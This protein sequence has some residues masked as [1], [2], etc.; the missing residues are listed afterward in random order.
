MGRA[1]GRDYLG[2]RVTGP[3]GVGA[4]VVWVGS[5]TR[6]LFRETGGAISEGFLGSKWHLALMT[7]DFSATYDRLHGDDLIYND[8]LFRDMCYCLE[9]ALGNSQFWF[10]YIVASEERSLGDSAEG[11]LRVAVSICHQLQHE[12]RNLS[13]LCW[14]QTLSNQAKL[15]GEPML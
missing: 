8:Q 7:A 13:H 14:D 4:S 3:R 6:L 1:I 15:D 11:G 12:V 5:G 9:D 10:L 2:A